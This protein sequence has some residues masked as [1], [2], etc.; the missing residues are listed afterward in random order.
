MRKLAAT[1]F[2]ATVFLA[3]VAFAGTSFPPQTLSGATFP[4]PSVPHLIIDSDLGQDQG[5]AAALALAHALADNGECQILAVLQSTSTADKAAAEQV[6][7]T[8]YNRGD[9]PVGILS[10]YTLTESDVYGATLAN[11]RP[12]TLT[13]TGAAVPG[14]ITV[15]RQTLAAQPN[16]SVTIVSI[17]QK[18]N[19]LDLWNS[20]A[21]GFSSL[22]GAQLIALKV[23]QI[24]VMGG[25][26]PTGAEFNLTSDP[27]GA[28]V[29]NSLAGSSIE[30]VFVGYTLGNSVSSNLT[31]APIYSP[32]RQAFVLAGSLTR[33]AWDELAV[34]Y[35]V[36]GLAFGGTNYF[37][38]GSAGLN[39]VNGSGD[40]TF[41]T[42]S[43]GNEYYLS[44]ASGMTTST[45]GSILSA[46]ETR[47]PLLNPVL[48]G[49]IGPAQTVPS[50]ASTPL[51]WH[52]LGAYNKV[53]IS[54]ANLQVA[55]NNQPI[56]A[57]V[58]ESAVFQTG[59][60]YAWSTNWMK[61]GGSPTTGQNGNGSDVAINLTADGNGV[62]NTSTYGANIDIDIP[63]NQS[64]QYTFIKY[65]SVF[66]DGSNVTAVLQGAAL[67]FH[68][69]NT[70]TDFEIYPGSGNW[71]GSGTC[72]MT[73]AG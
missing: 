10:D 8:Y 6:I 57:R 27:S 55:T 34:L 3:Q 66:T 23:K 28:Q 11:T 46:L 30:V 68:D 12:N 26:A 32:V 65:S 5:D 17:G 19:L 38:L 60:E 25:D 62:G 61:I 37:S 4:V 31:G 14:A 45:M 56:I 71:S 52:N 1:I 16:K 64:G 54:C 24:V 15:Y 43:G 70:I 47:G 49:N 42:S 73:V 59:S 2:A 20:P 29:L 41:S 33:P 7:N 58:G 67:M 72:Q 44:L 39:T 63:I 40:N 22:T 35:A 18:H 13:A 50:G 69:T 9:I 51:A 53:H 36:R 48:P 21:D